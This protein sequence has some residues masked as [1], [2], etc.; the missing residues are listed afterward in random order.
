MQHFSNNKRFKNKF[1][2]L[3]KTKQNKKKKKKKKKLSMEKT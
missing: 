3:S 1:T 2:K